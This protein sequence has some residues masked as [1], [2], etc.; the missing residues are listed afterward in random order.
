M[1]QTRRNNV[2]YHQG[3]DARLAGASAEANPYSGNDPDGRRARWALG[4][5]EAAP[6]AE[7]IET[8]PATIATGELAELLIATIAARFPTVA[9]RRSRQDAIAIED[10]AG[11]DWELQITKTRAPAPSAA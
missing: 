9:I 7:E 2:E 1:T 5:A 10:E 11:H 6:A 8:I 4:H 3:R